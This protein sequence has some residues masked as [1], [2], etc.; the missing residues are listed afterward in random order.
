MSPTIAPER[1][2][3][4]PVG[5]P[6]VDVT[7]GGQRPGSP[8]DA[9]NPPKPSK[10]QRFRKFL[11]RHRWLAALAVIVL[12]VGLAGLGAAL[13]GVG[14]SSADSSTAAGDPGIIDSEEPL[15]GRGGSDFDESSGSATLAEESGAGGDAARTSASL[16]PELGEAGAAPDSIGPAEPIL[17]EET[18][19]VT[20]IDRDLVRTATLDIDAKEPDTA[21][22]KARSVVTALGGRVAQEQ[23]SFSGNTSVVLTLAIPPKSFDKAMEQLADLGE[24]TNRTQSTD[25][26]TGR[27]TDMEG[28]ITT[29]KASITRLQGFL[30][31]ASDAGQIGMLESELLRR[32][33]ELE[34]IQ[35]QLRTIEAQ[36]A[37]STVTLTISEPGKKAEPVIEEDESVGFMDGLTRGWEA[38]TAVVNAIVVAL[39]A[40]APFLG[41][42]LLIWLV[43]RFARRRSAAKAPTVNAGPAAGTAPTDA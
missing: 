26:V 15:V 4:P 3:A 13:Q 19:Q 6:T 14:S 2:P 36:V 7:Q 23:S 38:F 18:P 34:G 35:G 27:V 31:E 12:L 1:P 39:A 9:P 25:D 20:G 43:V 10:S 21:S 29:L 28:R 16:A 40:I 24:V 17:P 33:T 11:G 42:G 30:A 37:E 8:G 22:A 41:I 5:T 32:E